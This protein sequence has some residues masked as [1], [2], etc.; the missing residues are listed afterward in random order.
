MVKVECYSGRYL[1][2]VVEICKL[3]SKEAGEAWVGPLD[4]PGLIEKIAMT[5]KTNAA[6][7][8][9]L[10]V[11]SRCAGF[12]YGREHAYP[13]NARRI[14]QEVF[15]Y[16]RKEARQYSRWFLG[17]V[18]RI[19]KARGIDLL[20]MTVLENYHRDGLAR[21]YG[22]LGYKPMETHLVKEL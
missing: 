12:L 1:I 4:V 7:M 16:I 2:D 15:L 10:I 5:A 3:F 22:M 21:F 14:W 19:M 6:D 20:I 13:A 9:L 17:E 18:E 11:D 8:L